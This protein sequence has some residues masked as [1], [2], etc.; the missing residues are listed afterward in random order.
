MNSIDTIKDKLIP[1]GI[2]DLSIT[3]QVYKELLTYATEIDILLKLIEEQ[4]KE[5]FIGSASSYGLKV[6]ENIFGENREYMDIEK[7]RELLEERLSIGGQ[8]FTRSGEEDILKSLGLDFY[9]YE[10]P[11]QNYMN[12]KCIGEYTNAQKNKFEYDVDNLLPSHL[13]IFLDFRNFDF[14][15]IDNLSYTFSQLDNK[16]MTW[17]EIEQ[18][19]V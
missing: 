9:L 15:Y 8:N 6:W 12:I 18:L 4:E 19:V 5:S 13:E 16:N 3:T 17:E 2:Y 11:R 14:D 7:R 10:Y 1:L